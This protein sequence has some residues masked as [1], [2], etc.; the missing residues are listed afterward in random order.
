MLKKWIAR[1]LIIAMMSVPLAGCSSTEPEQ[2]GTGTAS[3]NVKTSQRIEELIDLSDRLSFPEED[4]AEYYLTGEE[5][6]INSLTDHE[7]AFYLYDSTEQS[8]VAAKDLIKPW[9]QSEREKIIKITMEFEDAFKQYGVEFDDSI[10]I[11][12]IGSQSGLPGV[13]VSRQAIVIDEQ[14]L[15]LHKDDLKAELIQAFFRLYLSQNP[16]VLSELATSLT[17]EPVEGVVLPKDMMRSILIRPGIN[18]PFVYR[19]SRK[20]I[21]DK[22][23]VFWL[24]LTF[25]VD[26]TTLKDLMVRV[27]VAENGEVHLAA[28]SSENTYTQEIPDLAGYMATPLATLEKA[29]MIFGEIPETFTHPEDILALNFMYMILGR[30][31]TGNGSLDKLRSKLN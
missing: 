23:Q 18:K 21:E 2:S 29:Q 8:Q 5:S 17:Y 15:A 13:F 6:Y 4:K 7:A 16:D 22:T 11:V 20:G 14:Q 3:T 10:H 28:S 25:I 27:E 26:Q 9:T 31:V 12:K 19:D 1:G 24:P 30:P